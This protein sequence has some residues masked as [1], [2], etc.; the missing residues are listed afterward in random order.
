MQ[1]YGK[2]Q[3][4]VQGRCKKGAREEQGRS[5]GNVKIEC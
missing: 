3:K 1:I 5:K 4:R 2:N